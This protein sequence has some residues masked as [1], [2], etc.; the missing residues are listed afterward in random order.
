[1]KTLKKVLKSI[2]SIGKKKCS[3]CEAVL[4]LSKKVKR[5]TYEGTP[6]YEVWRCPSCNINI[7]YKQ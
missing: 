6:L 1:M 2:F 3:I 5:K 4:V 7:E